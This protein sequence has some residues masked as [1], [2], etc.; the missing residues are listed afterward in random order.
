MQVA[1]LSGL[2]DHDDVT[3]LCCSSLKAISDMSPALQLATMHC[4]IL[5]DPPNDLKDPPVSIR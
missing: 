1:F 4:F 2:V 3:T 5:Q